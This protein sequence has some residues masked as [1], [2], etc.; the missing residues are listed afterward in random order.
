MVIIMECIELV[1][2]VNPRRQ[3]SLEQLQLQLGQVEAT[4]V[5]FVYA[6][7]GSTSIAHSAAYA[8]LGFVSAG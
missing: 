2:R 5:K 4:S 3:V 7:P 8:S 1:R 6:L